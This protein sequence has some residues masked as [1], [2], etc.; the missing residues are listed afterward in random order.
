[1]AESLKETLIAVAK[2]ASCLV[3]LV[4]IRGQTGR[5]SPSARFLSQSRHRGLISNPNDSQLWDR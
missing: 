3:L 4:A 1:M 5:L 2:K